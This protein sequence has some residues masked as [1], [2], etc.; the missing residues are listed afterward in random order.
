[1]HTQEGKC[2]SKQVGVIDTIGARRLPQPLVALNFK[3]YCKLLTNLSWRC[4]RRY[5]IL[6]F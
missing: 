6:L 2:R 5:C 4:N 1:M 3:T